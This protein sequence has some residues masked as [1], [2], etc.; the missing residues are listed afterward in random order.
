MAARRDGGVRRSAAD[1]ARRT[2]RCQLRRLVG[3]RQHARLL[4]VGRTGA[5][6]SAT[7]EGCAVALL[8]GTVPPRAGSSAAWQSAP[9]LHAPAGS[10]GNSFRRRTHAEFRQASLFTGSAAE[11]PGRPSKPARPASAGLRLV[12]RFGLRGTAG[13]HR[14]RS[15]RVRSAGACSC[16]QQMPWRQES[17]C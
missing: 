5:S 6:R 12:W 14:I 8:S 16:L 10:M 15:F 1:V 9:L 4:L 2:S 13:K 3:S 7:A 11:L 17:V